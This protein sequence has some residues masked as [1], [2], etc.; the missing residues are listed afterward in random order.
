MH[1]TVSIRNAIII[2]RPDSE[3][4]YAH[5]WAEMASKQYGR[6]REMTTGGGKLRGP[7]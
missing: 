7:S 6:T 1:Y 5:W 3:R 4:D 2:S